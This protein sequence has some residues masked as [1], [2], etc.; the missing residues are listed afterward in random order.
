MEVEKVRDVNVDWRVMSLSVLNDKRDHLSKGYRG[1]MDRGWGPV[2][3]VIAAREKHGDAV[4]KPNQEWR[5]IASW[6]RE[7]ASIAEANVR[8]ARNARFRRD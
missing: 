6:A 3:V 5:R 7:L 4:V 8:R 2:R 1:L